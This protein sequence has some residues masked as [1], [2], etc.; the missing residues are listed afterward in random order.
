MYASETWM[1]TVHDPKINQND[2]KE[3]SWQ[4][5][6]PCIDRET[7]VRHRIRNISNKEI[8]MNIENWI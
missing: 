1:M 5:F 7:L 3:K 4:E 2:L 6:G 8:Y